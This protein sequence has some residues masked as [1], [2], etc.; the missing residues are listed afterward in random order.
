MRK[1]SENSFEFRVR[2]ATDRQIGGALPHARP[3]YCGLIE[4][5]RS[6]P[7]I[8]RWFPVS[9]DIN[10]DPEV[11]ELTDR[12][13][14]TGLKV[15]L[16]CLSIGDR[17]E[18]VLGPDLDTL[19]RSLAIKCNSTRS[20]V[21]L[22]LDLTVTRS[23]VDCDSTVRLHN[24]AKYHRTREPNRFPSEP[25]LTKPS[26]PDLIKIPAESAGAVNN[27]ENQARPEVRTELVN[28]A[29]RLAGNSRR[30]QQKLCQWVL[31]MFST[32][33]REPPQRI[34]AV[35]RASLAALEDQLSKDKAIKDMWGYLTVIFNKERTKY[36]EG[37][38]NDAYKRQGI[39]A[40]GEILDK[41]AKR[42]KAAQEV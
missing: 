33:K 10:S 40:F 1:I 38:E 13:G 26:E 5:S 28:T 24:Y 6:V 17:N 23:W 22:V 25:I 14:L 7:R 8:T 11:I 20:R 3:P 19:A 36:I 9:H 4:R 31:S 16:E 42:A 30:D 41:I 37:P 21:R 18:G 2:R 34:E 12:F 39:G 15:W 35:V 32:L 27:L 29:I